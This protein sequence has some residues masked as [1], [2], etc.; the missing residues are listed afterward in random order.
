MTSKLKPEADTSATG[1]SDQTDCR[2]FVRADGDLAP[3]FPGVTG[4]TS[5]DSARRYFAGLSALG[6]ARRLEVIAGLSRMVR[7]FAMAGARRRHPEQRDAELRLRVAEAM[8]GRLEE[9]FG[10]NRYLGVHVPVEQYQPQL[11]ALAVGEALDSLGIAYFVGGSLASGF[12]GEPRA[13]NGIDLVVELRESQI[14][15]LAR[16]LG[17]DFSVDEDGL[18]TAVRA[19]RSDNIFFLPFF[20]KI[21]LFVCDT[22]PFDQS[23]MA[24]RSRFEVEPGRFLWVKS[25]EDTVLRKLLW[26]RQGGEVVDSQWRDIAG[27]LRIS[28]SSMD[29]AYLDHWAPVLGVEDLLARARA[30]VGRT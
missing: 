1:P 20:T 13:T 2:P 5:P 30:E 7:S 25:A 8:Y 4:D 19:R 9:R 17:P 24:R 22:T 3:S 10:L 27:V 14:A 11:I 29:P 28:G 15:P 23:E 16:Q 18:R 12:Q 26:F 6:P 21:D